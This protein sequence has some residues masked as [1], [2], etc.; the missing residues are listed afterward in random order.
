MLHSGRVA[1]M[2][3]GEGKTL[4]ATLPM[5]LNALT[6]RGAH[7]VTVNDYLAKRDTQWMGPIY[8]L[9]G[10]TVAC[11]QHDTA[12]L[13]DPTSEV[14]DPLLNSLVPVPAPGGLR[15]RHYLRH[16]TTSSGSTIFETT[17]SRPRR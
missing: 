9:L 16:K 2:K 3:T 5:Y 15:G 14:E 7:L 11:L 10:L 1:E 13:F 8:H 6:G 12:Y 17:W 4:V